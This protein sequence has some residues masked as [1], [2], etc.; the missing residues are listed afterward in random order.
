MEKWRCITCGY[1]YNPVVGDPDGKVEAGVEYKD[2]PVD[3][4]CPICGGTKEDFE[5]VE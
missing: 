2:L 3:W 4:V 1:I 5:R